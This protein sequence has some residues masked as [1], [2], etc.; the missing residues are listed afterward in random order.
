MRT[1][2]AGHFDVINLSSADPLPQ[3]SVQVGA[4]WT[5]VL[6]SGWMSSKKR[7]RL[8][9]TA[10]ASNVEMRSDGLSDFSAFSLQLQTE[11]P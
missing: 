1:A 11:P 4:T 3:L 9:R 2:L 7:T 6:G 5:L 8:K 10:S